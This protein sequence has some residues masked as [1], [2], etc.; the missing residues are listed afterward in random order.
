MN[1]ME[2]KVDKITNVLIQFVLIITPLFFFP[3]TREFIILSKMYFFLYAVIV[4][5]LVSLVRLFLTRKIIWQKDIMFYGIVTFL[6]GTVLSIMITTSNKISALF[7]PTNGLIPLLTIVLFYFFLVASMR[8]N[9]DS[10]FLTI[11]ISGALASAVGIFSFIQPFKNT[12]LPANISFINSPIFNTI[13]T[14]VDFILFTIFTLVFLIAYLVSHKQITIVNDHSHTK[15]AAKKN[16]IK[17]ILYVC[18]TVILI[19]F[20]I[21]VFQLGKSIIMSDQNFIW[22]PFSISW[23]AAIEILKNPLSALFGVG[24][25]NF[26]SIFTKVKDMSYNATPFWQIGSFNISSSIFLHM[27]TETGL[28]GAAGLLLIVIHV[29]KNI[30]SVSLGEKIVGIFILITLFL[31]PPSFITF[32]VF[33]ISLAYFTA[34]IKQDESVYEAN[35]KSV[36]PV[37][38]STLAIYLIII[39]TIT[40]FTTISFASEIVFKNGMNAAASNDLIGLYQ[41]QR[42]AIDLNPYNEDFHLSFSQTNLLI[43]NNLAQKKKE[44]LTDND[45]T[46]ITQAIQAAIAEAKTAVS[47]NPS[48]AAH[49]QYLASVYK[50]VINVAQGSDLWTVAA[51]QKAVLLDP[52]NPSYR[53]ELGGVYYML[54]AYDEAEKMFEQAAALKPDWANA[55]YNLAWTLYQK[56]DYANAVDQMQLVLTLIDQ[57]TAKADYEQ[58]KKDLEMFKE[59]LGEQ[60]QAVE[61][62]KETASASAELKQVKPKT[63]KE[64]KLNL[65]TPPVATFEPKIELPKSASP[66][67]AITP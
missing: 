36:P 31:F 42:K 65:V 63:A 21:N 60:Q 1:A 51:Y 67:A 15:R 34:H 8:K 40:Y 49:W 25:G 41:S 52:Q 6:F 33:F 9:K 16:Y 5:L 32:F 24:V 12:N 14:Q 4:L 48:N 17:L 10:I 50:N 55:H 3:L 11:G 61:K 62:A 37:Y 66:S 27:L 18:F 13:G 20:I 23:Y 19:S 26:S 39:G 35:L 38:F 7:I 59:K 54:K 56:K 44:Q 58:A 47:L 2:N 30:S 43:A 29:I 64:E 45:K 57:K 28:I 46:T 53:V 22:P